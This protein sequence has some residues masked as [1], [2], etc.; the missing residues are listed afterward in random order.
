MRRLAPM[1]ALTLI[2]TLVGGTAVAAMGDATDAAPTVTGGAS[3][4]VEAN[5]KNPQGLSY[6]DKSNASPGTNAKMD[7]K[8]LAMDH[9]E[10]TPQRKM[11]H[12]KAKVARTG[13]T[14]VDANRAP[15][16]ITG[17]AAVNSTTGKS[18]R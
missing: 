1:F 18:G 9:E 10:A 14:G 17:D 16:E 4:T 15:V 5:T 13:Q 12:H 8:G 3:P 2:S 11:K 6:S 7:D